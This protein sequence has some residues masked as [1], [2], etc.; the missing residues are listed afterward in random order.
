MIR[1]IKKTFPLLR[2]GLFNN[3][4]FE[5]EVNIA[6]PKKTIKLNSSFFISNK[7]DSCFLFN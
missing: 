3:L 7:L 5:M 2:K 6:Y 1:G 4:N